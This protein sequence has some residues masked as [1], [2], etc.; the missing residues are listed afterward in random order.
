M[1]YENIAA[2][3]VQT[4]ALRAHHRRCQGR[5][6]KGPIPL[7]AIALAARLPGQALAVYLAIHHRS[8]LTRSDSVTLPKAL[9]D[10][11]GV[12][13]DAKARALYALEEASLAT[14]E[15][16]SGRAARITLLVA[17]NVGG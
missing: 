9:L 2:R 11:F 17:T 12:T 5:F 8:A 4:D 6:L 7:H 14:V 1:M 13:R 16:P 3:E 15:R 10:Q